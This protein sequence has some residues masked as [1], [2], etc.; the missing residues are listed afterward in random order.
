MTCVFI[1]YYFMCV[2]SEGSDE[3]ERLRRL[4]SIKYLIINIP[5]K[6]GVRDI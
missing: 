4:V 2:R 3:T 5:V 6:S 1:V